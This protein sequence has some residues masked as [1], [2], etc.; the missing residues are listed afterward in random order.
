[1]VDKI[2]VPRSPEVKV[3]ASTDMTPE[4]QTAFVN[5]MNTSNSLAQ[6]G[7]LGNGVITAINAGFEGWNLNI[8]EDAMYKQFEF[9]NRLA[10]I[11]EDLQDKMYEL[12]NKALNYQKEIAIKS[13]DTAKTLAQEE[14]GLQEHRI[15]AQKEVA[16]RRIEVQGLGSAFSQPSYFQ[17]SPSYPA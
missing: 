1:M 2:D 4:M 5:G 16:L 6:W 12:Q 15:D 11:K 7:M 8:K 9:M 13:Q 17:G 3:D 10:G 14:R